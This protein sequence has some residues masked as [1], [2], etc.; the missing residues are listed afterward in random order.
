[1]PRTAESFFGS[2]AMTHCS[3][4]MCRKKNRERL[5]RLHR[6]IPRI[7]SPIARPAETGIVGI[8]G[9]SSHALSEASL[10]DCIRV[11]DPIG[12]DVLGK[13]LALSSRDRVLI[14]DG[15]CGRLQSFENPWFA[16]LHSVAFSRDGGRLLVASSGYDTLFELSVESGEVLW[17][18]N[19]WEHG[20]SVSVAGGVEFARCGRASAAMPTEGRELV[21]VDPTLLGGAGVP[22]WQRPVH[23]NG[24][25]YDHDGNI[26]V[27]L[28]HNG[29]AAKIDR[30]SK[31]CIEVVSN[32]DKP[33]AFLPDRERG[34]FFWIRVSE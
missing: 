33:H 34:Y 15:E 26:L 6:G 29:K 23:L 30:K 31:V 24:A 5:E 21:R 22:I 12:I 9:L 32:L 19:S 1:M 4:G 18:W 13:S 10:A 16:T 2:I 27:S 7:G 25:A 28:F 14:F 17:E 11:T 20:Y 3:V 8:A